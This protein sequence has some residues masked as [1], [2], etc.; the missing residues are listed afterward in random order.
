[1]VMGLN[2]V[3]SNQT[4]FLPK[5]FFFFGMK[6]KGRRNPSWQRSSQDGL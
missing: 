1:M 4:F 3:E 5:F 6:V 2:L